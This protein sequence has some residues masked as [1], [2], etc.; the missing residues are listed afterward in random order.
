VYVLFRDTIFII[1]I[2]IIIILLVIT[3]MHGIYNYIPETNRVYRV[4][5]VAAVLYLQFCATCIFT[6]PEKYVLHFDISTLR[7]VCAVPN[8]TAV[9]QFVNFVLF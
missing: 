7:T 2:T 8:T 3:F 4:H 1:V 5:I 6:S 9:L